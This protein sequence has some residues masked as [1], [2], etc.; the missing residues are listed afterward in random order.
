MTEHRKL[1]I[2]LLTTLILVIPFAEVLCPITGGCGY[3][4][5]L[6]SGEY[7]LFERYHSTYKMN[8]DG[9]G[10]RLIAKSAEWPV[11]SPTG[12]KVVF[13][14]YGRD[15][16]KRD[17]FSLD[18]LTNSV[19]ELTRGVGVGWPASV[20]KDGVVAF[21]TRELNTIQISDGLTARHTNSFSQVKVFEWSP[22]GKRLGFAAT[23]G[24][25]MFGKGWLYY[26]LDYPSGAIKQIA[27]S[28][29]RYPSLS[30][31]PDGN[32]VALIQGG[33][34]EILDLQSNSSHL[35]RQDLL[36]QNLAWSPDGANIVVEGQDERCGAFAANIYVIRI[37]DNKNTNVSH[38][39]LRCRNYHSPQWSANGTKVI[40]VGFHSVGDM[41][42]NPF[43]KNFQDNI[44]VVNGDGSG[45]SKLSDN[46]DV[47]DTHPMCC[48]EPT[49]K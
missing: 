42:L 5:A 16:T 36:L 20:S 8:P 34:I 1:S 9:S 19:Q 44:Y 48:K 28:A 13:F 6:S 39:W 31:S 30:W 24:E 38:R 47:A 25:Q 15:R 32:S 3:S 27:E 43:A 21:S 14:R 26:V 37:S 49:K 2:G 35:L 23:Q 18:I 45:H 10:V 22:D 12:D 41:Q 11:C 46:D 4:A 29:Y 40:F 7:I 17:L 33:A